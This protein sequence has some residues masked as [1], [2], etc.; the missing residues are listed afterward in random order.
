MSST[1]AT[2]DLNGHDLEAAGYFFTM[3]GSKIT[4]ASGPATFKLTGNFNTTGAALNS[5]L[6]GH[7]SFEMATANASKI[8]TQS[9]SSSQTDG[10]IIVS[11]G[12]LTLD[13]SV[14]MPNLRGIVLGVDGGDDAAKLDIPAT[15]ITLNSGLKLRRYGVGRLGLA[16]G[17]TLTVSMAFENDNSMDPGKYSGVAA[18]G[19]KYVDWI[20]GAGILEV[21]TG[22]IKKGD[23][24]W[25]GAATGGSWSDAA[26]W[27]VDGAAAS[28]SPGNGDRAVI[29]GAAE[30]VVG[31][32]EAAS[33]NA[34]GG[35][36]LLD[37]ESVVTIA[38]RTTA[39]QLSFPISGAGRLRAVD[40][41]YV[42]DSVQPAFDLVVSGDNSA[43]VGEF[44]F[45]NTSVSVE[46]AKAFSKT[47]RVTFWGWFSYASSYSKTHLPMLKWRTPGVYEN[48]LFVYGGGMGV[49]AAYCDG[50]VTNLGDLVYWNMMSS[51]QGSTVRAKTYNATGGTGGYLAFGGKISCINPNT[52][53]IDTS[54]G[55]NL[56]LNG[57][58]EIFG[59][60][61]IELTADQMVYSDNGNI[62]WGKPVNA[63][64]QMNCYPQLKFTR[65]N[66]DANSALPL[67]VGCDQNITV[68]LN[69]CDQQFKVFVRSGTLTANRKFSIKSDSPA[70][71][72]FKH[73]SASELHTTLD[74]AVSLCLD[75]AGDDVLTLT[76]ANGGISS[77]TGGL[78]VA[79]GVMT[80][81]STVRMPNLS[82]IQVGKSDSDVPAR[83][84]VAS[85]SVV[86][87]PAK[88]RE[89][90]MDLE[91]AGVGCLDLPAG[92]VLKV[93][94]F[95]V[96][97]KKQGAGTYGSGNFPGRINGSGV[98]R[99]VGGGLFLIVK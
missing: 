39:P 18:D 29:E 88:E 61:A 90:Q 48:K 78:A 81:N 46:S 55:I 34:L 83:L 40:V 97:G 65:A 71:L 30:V 94:N 37:A 93:R 69:G 91:L 82:S 50:G 64:K 87:N 89:C 43:F 8:V 44:F 13:A 27:T 70:R 7:V 95:T 33:F 77:T 84:T 60:D 21:A 2:F 36:V 54:G 76:T 80:L 66:V 67:I 17:V 41:G 52:G 19:V 31:D 22:G 14:N 32:D 24:V 38:N 16:S 25:S 85:S 98:V 57:N 4:S 92:S 99:V 9:G 42:S 51:W 79:G 73:S 5:D 53:K 96:N 12:T 62:V 11:K 58:V 6:N 23:Y 28:R 72:T 10:S 3:A 35:L 75:G 26:N 59:N 47:S 56:D 86:L 63:M 1:T 49:L 74:G 68:D 15:G 20:D 45:T